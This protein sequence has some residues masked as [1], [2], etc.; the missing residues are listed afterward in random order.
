MTPEE[1]LKRYY[2]HEAFRPG[3]KTIVEALLQGR[4]ALAIM[5]T[6]AGKSI[7]YQIPALMKPGVTLVV[8]PL[9]SLM[10]D[11]VASLIQAGIPAAYINSSLTSGQVQTALRRACEGRYK[12][13]YIAPERLETT[14]ME[15]LIAHVNISLVAV[16]EA[17]CVSQWGQDFRPSYLKIA[18]FI[19]R[20]PQRPPVGAFTATATQRV[21]D[22]I[23]SLLDMKQPTRV[24]TGF[25]RKNLF[26][27]VVNPRDKMAYT[28]SY[29]R[30]HRKQS[31][32]IYCST[33]KAVEAVC[34]MLQANDLPATRYHAGLDDDERRVNQEDF[35]YDRAPIM[36]ATNAF[37]M[38]IDKSNVSY[39]LH[40]NMPKD[41][42][43]YYQEAGRA[44]RDG[45][46]AECILLF[47]P[48]DVALS[49]FM[50]GKIYENATLSAEQKDE[51]YRRD[52]RRLEE[53]VAYCQS[54]DCLRARILRYFG[55]THE[56]ECGNCGRCTG[57][58]QLEDITRQAHSLIACVSHLQ[59]EL[60]YGLGLVT[61][62]NI[63][64]GSQDASIV[65]RG[66]N[67]NVVYGAM[68]GTAPEELR[69][70]ADLLI[71]RGYLSVSTGKYPTLNVTEAGLRALKNETRVTRRAMVRSNAEK[72]KK[73]REKKAGAPNEALL[74]R[75]KQ[76]RL[77]LAEK[78]HV[79][80]FVIFSNATLSEMASRRPTTPDQMLA[81]T[82][83]GERKA[84]LY[85]RAFMTAIE[86]FLREHPEY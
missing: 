13:I 79:P 14:S 23:V 60:G 81:I 17:H 46:R 12:I 45:E 27:D 3:Q 66:L 25:D 30:Q 41:I 86:D 18:P 40:Y 50:I 36:V 82:G 84:A 55:E 77:G 48:A 39:V 22:D 62:I 31:G 1:L 16:D 37:G 21:Q 72:A 76:V 85:G 2:G 33:R 75:L 35:V 34:D 6:G 80:A 52:M 7:C 11:Q 54:D 43:S 61:I 83:V 20:L 47:A 49:R 74:E 26:Y 10:A 69:R 73:K 58:Y 78:A 44:G 28:L 51:I 19:A 15:A 64:T 42:E 63:L 57:L 8:S 53:M 29:V 68:R 4:D 38:G 65:R 56:G 71:S 67:D 32:I 24:V 70:V 5:P 9:I 59:R